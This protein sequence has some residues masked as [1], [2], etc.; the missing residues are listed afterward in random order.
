VVLH[1]KLKKQM[2]LSTKDFNIFPKN[3]INQWWREQTW[4]IEIQ[5]ESDNWGKNTLIPDI[6][7]LITQQLP[8]NRWTSILFYR[9]IRNTDSLENIRKTLRSFP[10]KFFSWASVGLNISHR[11]SMSR[12]V[13]ILFSSRPFVPQQGNRISCDREEFKSQHLKNSNSFNSIESESDKQNNLE[14]SLKSTQPFSEMKRLPGK[15]K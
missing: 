2:I 6:T 8:S 12:W 3:N 10:Q 15:K 11:F 9:Y 4:A 5:S 1:N 14:S 7:L 13:Q